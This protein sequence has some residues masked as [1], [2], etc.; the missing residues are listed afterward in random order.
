MFD[1]ISFTGCYRR[2]ASARIA[3]MPETC[4][5]VNAPLK[6]EARILLKN[7]VRFINH[8]VRKGL[9]M[10]LIILVLP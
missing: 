2:A 4:G 6:S 3:S 1:A 7:V 5:P 9:N 10:T 8:L